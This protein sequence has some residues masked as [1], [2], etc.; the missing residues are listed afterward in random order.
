MAEEIANAGRR[1][2]RRSSSSRGAAEQCAA[3]TPRPGVGSWR[4]SSACA[5]WI[6]SKCM[7]THG[8]VA[9]VLAVVRSFLASCVWWIGPGTQQGEACLVTRQARGGFMLLRFAVAPSGARQS[10]SLDSDDP[11]VRTSL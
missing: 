8:G 11:T 5:V 10:V 4:S 9:V 3:V 1:A 6:W 2:E 7:D